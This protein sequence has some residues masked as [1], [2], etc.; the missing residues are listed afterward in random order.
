MYNEMKIAETPS[1]QKTQTLHKLVDQLVISLLPQT[2]ELRSLI[3][4]DVSQ[5][6]EIDTDQNLLATVLGDLLCDTVLNSWNNCI[7]ISAKVYGYMTLVHVRNNFRESNSLALANFIQAQ[8]LAERL[9]GCISITNNMLNGTTIA[10]SFSN[11]ATA[12]A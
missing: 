6:I 8:Q 1:T 3:V 2:S 4:N 7:R 12:A 10:F 9:G 5:E 11:P